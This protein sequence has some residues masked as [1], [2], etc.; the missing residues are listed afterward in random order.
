M[1]I[2][3]PSLLEKVSERLPTLSTPQ[4]AAAAGIGVAVAAAAGLAVHHARKADIHLLNGKADKIYHL[5]PDADAW[6]LTL[7]GDSR[8]YGS[9]ATK[10]E[11]LEVARAMAN[12]NQPSELVIHLADGS[13]QKRHSYGTDA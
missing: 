10:D 8:S 6:E 12:E 4:K 1:S 9:F 5:K 13:E 3:S 7:E 2:E 11:G